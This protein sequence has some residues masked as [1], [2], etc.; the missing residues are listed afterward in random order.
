VARRVI[1]EKVQAPSATSITVRSS[2]IAKVDTETETEEN[3][4][5]LASPRVTIFRSGNNW[6][7]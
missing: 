6:H 2:P 1:S 3:R 7:G 4:A 5:D